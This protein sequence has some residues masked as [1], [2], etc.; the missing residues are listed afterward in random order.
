[1][2][3]KTEKFLAQYT[4]AQPVLQRFISAHLPDLDAVEDLMQEVA[5]TLWKKFDQYRP[6]TS[7]VAWALRVSQFEILHKR[8]SHSRSRM[9]LTPDLAEKAA[10][11]YEQQDFRLLESRK[12]ALD[13]CLKKL[14]APHRELLA[15]RY[16]EGRSNTEISRDLGRN[17][18]QIR[19]Q[20]ARIRASLRKCIR[21]LLTQQG[22]WA[23]E[24]GT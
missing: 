4:S 7:F 23:P 17:P 13:Q 6:G 16:R 21:A 15:A 1:M 8:R 24:A 19:T 20:L 11:Y 22:G 14:R 12:Q 10:R 3:T 18:S 9:V 2:D 5:I